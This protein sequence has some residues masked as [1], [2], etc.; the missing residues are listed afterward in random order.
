MVTIMILL[1]YYESDMVWELHL[2]LKSHLELY[3][4]QVITT[5]KNQATD[6]ALYDRGTAAKG[7]DLYISL[8]SNA[9]GSALNNNVDY[10]VSY[11]GINRKAD[12]IGLLLAQTMKAL[13]RP[14][15]PPESKTRAVT[16]E[17]TMVY[18]VV[19]LR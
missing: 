4:F 7:C 8:H 1:Q 16:T 15:K 3:G 2:K 9:T 18:C 19:Q 11:C 13:C 10:P 12:V 14:S 6:L 5:R 17:I